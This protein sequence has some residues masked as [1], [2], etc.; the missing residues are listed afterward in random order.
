M[1]CPIPGEDPGGEAGLERRDPAG[2]A[3][4]VGQGLCQDSQMKLWGFGEGSGLRV[5]SEG[6]DLRPMEVM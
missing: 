5:Y 4:C 3:E 6:S 2:P 1:S